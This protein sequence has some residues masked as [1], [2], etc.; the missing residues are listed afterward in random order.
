M[1]MNKLYGDIVYLFIIVYIYIVYI[2]IFLSKYDPSPCIIE[3]IMEKW[4]LSGK[5]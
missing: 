3:K 4:T 5:K 2:Y 1:Q